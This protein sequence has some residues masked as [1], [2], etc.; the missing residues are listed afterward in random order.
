M[1]DTPLNDVGDQGPTSLNHIIGQST[2]K[3]QVTVALE[4]AFADNKKFDN[5]LLVGGPGL[6]KTAMAKVIAKEMA[7]PFLEILG[8]SITKIDDFYAM[9]LT[10]KNKAVTHIDECHLL[11]KPLQTA[12]Y[13][14]M[15]QHKIVL[16]SGSLFCKPMV[17]PVADFTLL[18]STTD[19]YRL[20]QPLRDRARLT[21]RFDYYSPA[22]LTKIVELYGRS[23]HWDVA[24]EIPPLIAQRAKGTPRLALGLLQ[25]S[26]RVCRAAGETS[27]TPGHFTRACDLAK[28][29]ALGLDV[30][31]QK[32]L[33]LLQA[34]PT[35]LNVLAS[36]LGM[37]AQ[38]IAAVTEPIL[39]RIGLLAKDN[40]GR[41]VLTERGREHV[42]GGI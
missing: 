36:Q 17:L 32:Y 24:A 5:A 23:L 29:D 42:G 40:D 6:G 13:M 41:R 9:L 4:A 16:P 3:A 19:E 35:R 37:P 31:E 33:G 28:V 26:R 38:T 18:L 11:R 30:V 8:Q 39:M 7:V 22:E 2:V 10:A 34:G 1:T 21:L 25:A 15:D 27:I 20:L 12:L 14:A